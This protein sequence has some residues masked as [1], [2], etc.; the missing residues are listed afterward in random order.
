MKLYVIGD[1]TVDHMHF[2][3]HIPKAG[4]DIV[5]QQS[6]LLPGGAGGTM[7]FHAANLG[8]TVTLAARV[9]NDPFATVALENLVRSGVSQSALQ[10][11]A[12]TMT[13]TVTI[14]VTGEERTM[15]SPNGANRL[16]DP[17]LLEKKLLEGQDALLISAYALI[18]GA[19]REY[20]QKAIEIAKKA[21][22]PIFIDLGTGAVNVAGTSL[23]EWVLGADYLLMNQLE[24]FRITG[25]S[26]ISF[27]LERLEA[28]GLQ[29]VVVKVGALGAILWTPK[30]S[31]LLEGYSVTNVVDTTGAGD[32]FSA[33]FAHGVLSAFAL[34]RAVAYAN[35]AG[36]M[37]TLAVGAQGTKLLHTDILAKL[38]QY[39]AQKAARVASKQTRSGKRV[40][41]KD[42]PKPIPAAV[43]A[44]PTPAAIAP[45]P[46]VAVAEEPKKRG[47]KR[48]A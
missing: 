33:A 27:A 10:Y 37:A 14:L 23:L 30:E 29:T 7:A 24:L 40:K 4:E 2:L 15:I 26:S 17:A 3:N 35:I 28:L 6:A 5:P 25:E 44:K 38:E 32:A 12:Q 8:H 48:A 20:T 36:A 1:V 18:G 21:G 19:Q 22:I 16:L 43:E 47:R 46:V 13:S 9:G 11:D 45:K 39:E 41:P 34:P 42:S 31:E